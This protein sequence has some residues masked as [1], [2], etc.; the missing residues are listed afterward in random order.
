MRVRQDKG[1]T[2]HERR[3][4]TPISLQYPARPDHILTDSS[5]LENL[6]FLWLRSGSAGTVEELEEQRKGQP[7]GWKTAG[8]QERLQTA[9]C[10]G[11]YKPLQASLTGTVHW[12]NNV[13]LRTMPRSWEGGW[14]G[15][16]TCQQLQLELELEDEN[17]KVDDEM[18]RA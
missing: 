7:R 9:G 3:V 1:F 6:T 14:L 13:I 11:E 12:Q 16:F 4:V 5:R 10:F 17:F 18:F 15:W 2:R 8:L